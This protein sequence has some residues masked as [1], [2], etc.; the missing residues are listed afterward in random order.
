MAKTMEVFFDES[1]FRPSE[2]V[3]L[4]AGKKYMIT[5]NLAPEYPDL[6]SRMMENSGAPAAS[7]SISLD[8][9]EH[10]TN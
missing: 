9:G 7:G 6:R 4:E 3:H 5:V 10:Q 8:R 1:V 2:A